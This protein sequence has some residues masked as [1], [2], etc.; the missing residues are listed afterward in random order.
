MLAYWTLYQ[1]E[2]MSTSII[3]YNMVECEGEDTGTHSPAYPSNSTQLCTRC[4]SS[5]PAIEG[6]ELPGRKCSI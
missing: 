2:D 6:A 1:R 3:A 5:I 4:E